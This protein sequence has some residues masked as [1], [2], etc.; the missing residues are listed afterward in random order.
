MNLLKSG[1][2]DYPMVLLEE[3]GVDMADPATYQAVIDLTDDLVTQLE[4]ELSKL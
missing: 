4:T 1:G 2:S 3:A